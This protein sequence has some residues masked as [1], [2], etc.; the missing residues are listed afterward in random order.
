M[1]TTIYWAIQHSNR[2]LH[3]FRFRA[4]CWWLSQQVEFLEW[5]LRLEPLMPSAQSDLVPS[6]AEQRNQYA[7]S[8]C[9][10]GDA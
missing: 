1:K 6:P 3:E 4:T 7:L 5:Q 8:Q 9:I 10:L 2:A